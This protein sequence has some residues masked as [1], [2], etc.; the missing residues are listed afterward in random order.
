MFSKFV[1]LYIGTRPPPH[2]VQNDFSLVF[3]DRIVHRQ[4]LLKK[5]GLPG[6]KSFGFL[7]FCTFFSEFAK[8]IE[9]HVKLCVL[10]EKINVFG[11]R[12]RYN[13][14]LC[15]VTGLQFNIENYRAWCIP[16]FLAA[17]QIHCISRS[18][19]LYFLSCFSSSKARFFEANR[20]FSIFVRFEC[21]KIPFSLCSYM[22]FSSRNA[23]IL[24]FVSNGLSLISRFHK[25]FCL[26][27]LSYGLKTPPLVCVYFLCFS[28]P[29]KHFLEKYQVASKLHEHDKIS[30]TSEKQR[31]K[32]MRC[33][34]NLCS[35]IF[36]HTLPHEVQHDFS[37]VFVDRIAHC[38][39]LL[40]VFGLPGLKSFV[41]L[42]FCTFF[43]EFAQT[44][45]NYVKVCVLF[46]KIN[47][48]GIRKRYNNSL[49][50]I[51]GLQ[52]NIENHRVWCI[53]IFLEAVQI[54]CI[55]R[56]V[57]PYFWSCFSSSKAHFL[58]QIGNAHFSFDLNAQKHLFHC[59]HTCGFLRE[60]Q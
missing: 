35:Y 59:V 42:F 55:S 47:A 20:E 9:N 39:F 46:E 13:N 4:F 37:L 10:F 33:F 41:F 30:L 48:F 38:Q 32:R 15:G 23:V 40:K 7:F 34:Q 51:T 58:K 11:M 26:F 2:E 25:S 1:F 57:W 8:T 22:W 60:I 28:T 49:C 50:G 24:E 6:P 44:I 14:S 31:S 52:C 45:K 43:W 36:T 12:K 29:M 3:V 17:A 16:I 18:V 27:H 5:F 19:C 56:S 21:A 54:H 53:P